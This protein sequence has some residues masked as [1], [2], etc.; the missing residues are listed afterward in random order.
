MPLNEPKNQAPLATPS[1]A[2]PQITPAQHRENRRNDE[3]ATAMAEAIAR[4]LNESVLKGE[5]PHG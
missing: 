5:L 3:A 4:G 1:T 2:E